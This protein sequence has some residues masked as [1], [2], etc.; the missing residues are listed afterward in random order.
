MNWTISKPTKWILLLAFGLLFLAACTGSE[1][2]N[3]PSI[4][5]PTGISTPEAVTT[6]TPTSFVH[7]TTEPG[8]PLAAS[9][10]GQGITLAE[11]QAELARARS[12]SE[13]GLT[14]YTDEDVL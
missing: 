6:A 13:T 4:P 2:T 7:P 5:D 14:S 12:A 8:I 9:V 1:Q 3:T 11:Y 10:N